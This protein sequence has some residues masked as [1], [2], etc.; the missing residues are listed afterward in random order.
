MKKK[1]ILSILLALALLLALCGC[2][3]TKTEQHLPGGSE[4]SAPAADEQPGT[5][6]APASTP[7]PGAENAPVIEGLT[8]ESTAEL[9]YADQFAIYRYEGG[10][11]YIDMKNSDKMLVVPEGGA[12]PKGLAKDVV[13]VQQPL[14]HIYLPAT[15]VMALFDALDALDRIAFVG[16]KTWYTENATA[17]MERGDFIYAGKYNTPD[18]EMLLAGSCDLAIESTMILHNPEVKE[19]LVEIG[20]KTVVERSSYEDHPLGRTEWIKVYGT[21]LGL[22]DKADAVFSA[23]MEKVKALEALAPTGKTVAFFYVNT[24]GN[25]VTYKS[26]GYLPSMIKIAGGEYIFSDLGKEDDTGKLSTVNMSMEQFY[27]AAVN[28]DVI[29]YNC[30]IAA[31]LHTL[32]DLTSLSPVLADFKAVK[33]GNAWCTTESM[34]QQTDKMG[35]IIEEMNRIFS[36]QTDGADLEYIFRLE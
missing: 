10:Y 25:V 8:Y 36:G 33:E 21:L 6:D 34:Y 30:S 24:Q 2:G 3:G 20:I 23:Q 1:Q 27:H 4:E 17:A 16:S 19:K 32:G 11:R 18:Y 14:Q 28:A 12:V 26:E 7:R 31:Q 9:T 5:A 29:I 13:V 15:S 22:E 35:T